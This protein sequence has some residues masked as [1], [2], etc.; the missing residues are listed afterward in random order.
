[1]SQEVS[2]KFFKTESGIISSLELTVDKETYSAKV[3]EASM[4]NEVSAIKS[5]FAFKHLTLWYVYLS[6][7]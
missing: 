1:M 7:K 5:I 4:A 2:Y 6:E 3:M